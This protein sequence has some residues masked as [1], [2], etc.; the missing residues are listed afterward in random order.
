[1]IVFIASRQ[2]ILKVT[3]DF[4]SIPPDGVGGGVVK[5]HHTWRRGASADGVRGG[6]QPVVR[7]GAPAS[8]RPLWQQ[9]AGERLS[10]GFVFCFFL[11]R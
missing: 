8:Q 3:I 11:G 2:R 5:P 7:A 9:E 6:G 4:R 1:M 10:W